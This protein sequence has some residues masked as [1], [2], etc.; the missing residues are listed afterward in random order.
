MG[1]YRHTN[2]TRKD[3]VVRD[4]KGDQHV[5]HPGKSMVLKVRSNLTTIKIESVQ[6]EEK[7]IKT[8]KAK[9]KQLKEDDE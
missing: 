7:P 4:S 5:L 1:L 8:K 2:I 3:V 9:T 6:E